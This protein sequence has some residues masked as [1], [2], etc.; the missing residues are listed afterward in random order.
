MRFLSCDTTERL[1]NKNLFHVVG[2][3]PRP[4][5][6]EAEVARAESFAPRFTTR[7]CRPD[8]RSERHGGWKYRTRISRTENLNG[9]CL[10]AIYLSYVLF[11]LNRS[12]YVSRTRNAYARPRRRRGSVEGSRKWIWILARC[13]TPPP[14][15][16]IFEYEQFTNNSRIVRASRRYTTVLSILSNR[17][18]GFSYTRFNIIHLY[19]K[20]NKFPRRYF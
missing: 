20:N 12:I 5:G 18:T 1:G 8:T 10:T 17:N 3:R 6:R 7:P 11:I 13:R 16:R 19:V 4:P 15:P 2:L 14:I 9:T